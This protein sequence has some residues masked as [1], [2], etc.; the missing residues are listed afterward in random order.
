M[1]NYCFNSNIYIFQKEAKW[2]AAVEFCE[3]RR[4]QFKVVTEDELGIK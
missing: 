3:D 2:K 1:K 4:I